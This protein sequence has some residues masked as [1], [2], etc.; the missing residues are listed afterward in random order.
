MNCAAAASSQLLKA[1]AQ[2]NAQCAGRRG[3]PHRHALDL[4]AGKRLD[5]CPSGVKMP[6]RLFGYSLDTMKPLQRSPK[7]NW[8]NIILT[9]PDWPADLTIPQ[10]DQ[11]PEDS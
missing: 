2:R 10:E 6:F 5:P 1:G 9:G 3:P 4:A 8:K 7:R 11:L